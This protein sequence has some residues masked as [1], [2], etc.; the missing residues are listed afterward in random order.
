MLL[1][2][3]L[4]E[5]ITSSDETD[6]EDLHSNMACLKRPSVNLRFCSKPV[7]FLKELSGPCSVRLLG[8]AGQGL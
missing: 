7:I 8:R 3:G 1:H 2:I 4:G 6:H 5:E